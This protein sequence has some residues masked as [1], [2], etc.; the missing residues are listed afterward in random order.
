MYQTSTSKG[1]ELVA[2]RMVREFRKLGQKAYLITSL[3]HDG[4]EVV[5]AESLKKGPGYLYTGD[6]VLKIPLIRVDSYIAKWPPRRIIF[7]DF[8]HTLERIVDKFELNVLITHSTLWNGP[9]EAAKFITWRRDM[10]S[11]GGYQDPIVFCH[12]SHL[13]EAS[14]Q[15]YSL[16]ELTFR[17]AWNKFS[18]TK[19]METANLILVVTP[20]EKNSKVKMGAKP[21]KVFL[22]PGGVDDEVFLH[23]AAEDTADFLK[24]HNINAGTRIVSYLGTIEERKN[25]MAVLKI[26][27]KLKERQGLH[28]I[29]AGR[30]DSTYAEEFVELANSLPNVT[31]LGEIDEKEKIQLI[32]ASYLNIIMS[33][34]EALGIAQLEFMYCGV[35]VITSATGGQSWVVQNDVEGSHVKGP[36]DIDGA[37]NAIVKLLEDDNKYRQMSSNAKAKA[38]KLTI[39]RLVEELD[40]AIEIEMMKESGMAGIPAEVQATLVTPE[41]ALKTWTA[42]A[43]GIV[44]TNKRIFIRQGIISRTVTELRYADIKSIEHARRY[45]WRTLLSG[46]MISAFFLI[47]PSLRPFFSRAFVAQ[48]ESWVNSIA[49]STPAWLTSEMIT[50]LLLPLLPVLIGI[51]LFLLGAR[52]GFNLYG[53]GIK[54]LYLPRRFKEA[55]GFIREKIDSLAP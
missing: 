9:E 5:P 7:R 13:Q 1:Q 47:A 46:V 49:L 10:R 8:I 4:R 20:F 45:P 53:P 37:C 17:T 51:V 27:E 15:R 19:I 43:S 52:L 41:H 30:G 34:L 23:F 42:G 26:A 16:S 50:Q 28:F 2:Q 21:E 25:P 55:I 3:F 29:L 11:V 24:R 6:S 36:D 54:P 35:P 44:A 12:M 39:S 32:K 40:T 48:I 22:F 18:L 33:H 31:Y 14:P 38:S